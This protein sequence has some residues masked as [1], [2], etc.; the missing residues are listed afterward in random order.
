MRPSA[1]HPRPV[2]P[3]TVKAKVRP[4]RCLLHHGRRGAVD[5]GRP[6]PC[7]ACPPCSAEMLRATGGQE[8]GQTGQRG[9]P[10]AAWLR[11]SRLPPSPQVQVSLMSPALPASLSGSNQRGPGIPGLRG[12]HGNKRWGTSTRHALLS[13]PP[14]T[15]KKIPPPVGLH[16]LVLRGAARGSPSPRKPGARPASPQP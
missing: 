12:P 4:G 9:G 6:M 14:N 3:G 8:V 15:Y 7:P 16:Q 13:P 1:A 10:A 5:T 11:V 2:R